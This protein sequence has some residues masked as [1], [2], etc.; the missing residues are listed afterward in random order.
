MSALKQSFSRAESGSAPG[1]NGRYLR[2]LVL[3]EAI[4]FPLTSGK[5]IRTFSIL[6]RLARLHEITFLC[7]G[8]APSD[9]VEELERAGIHVQVC[10][11]LPVHE[12]LSLYVRLLRNLPQ[13][14]PYSVVKHTTTAFRS[15]LLQLLGERSFDIVQCEWTPYMTYAECVREIPIVAML[16]NIEADIWRRRS[17]VA[18][19]LGGLFFAAQG[20]RMERFEQRQFG[21]AAV[22]I[23]VS[24][25]DR[26]RA[27]QWGAKDCVVA[28][29]GVDLQTY[30]LS[31]EAKESRDMIF[32]GSLDWFPNQDAVTYMAKEILPLVRKVHPE[33]TFTIVGRKP[34]SGL[35]RML[36]NIPGALLVGEVEDVRP[37]L[38]A[39]ALVVVPLRVG[40][41]S[42]LKILEAMGAG[43]AVL[44]TSIGAEGLNV[45]AGETLEI[46]DDAE[47][48]ASSATRMLSHRTERSRMAQRARALVEAQY[49]W[50][51]IAAQVNNVWLATAQQ[52]ST[53]RSAQ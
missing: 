17:E 43:R 9:S 10:G 39:A 48:L 15:A 52:P 41:G 4:P 11:D 25:Q 44:A 20:R 45:V 34:P 8:P 46:A 36:A 7:H 53:A 22:C 51:K 37:Y 12:G 1:A 42:R 40:G 31:P 5:A 26:Q 30:A 33:A 35:R 47:S 29:N 28:E 2:V 50:D 32:V 18:G 49:G 24:E 23:A 27:L 19:T 6:K 21:H 13:T 16:H 14:Q 38:S 3:D